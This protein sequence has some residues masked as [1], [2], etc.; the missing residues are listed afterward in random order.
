[1]AK[2]RPQYSGIILALEGRTQDALEIQLRLL[3]SSPH[4]LVLP[5]L[6]EY[7]EVDC[8]D[9]V[10]FAPSNSS[11]SYVS[12]AP[13]SYASSKP[14]TH[15]SAFDARHYVRSVYAAATAR[16]AIVLNFLENDNICGEIHETITPPQKTVFLNGGTATSHAL[17]IEAIREHDAAAG[18]SLE[19]AALIF[20]KLVGNGFAGLRDEPAVPSMQERSRLNVA[21][22]DGDEGVIDEDDS[23]MTKAMRAADALDRKTKSLQPNTHIFDPTITNKP[24]SRSLSLPVYGEDSALLNVDCQQNRASPSN[25]ESRGDITGAVS[26]VHNLLQLEDS[27]NQ[28]ASSTPATNGS[29]IRSVSLGPSSRG[30]TICRRP[31]CARSQFDDTKAALREND[32]GETLCYHQCHQSQPQRAR[33]LERKLLALTNNNA[34]GVNMDH[35]F[36]ASSRETSSVRPQPSSSNRL[37]ARAS[38]KDMS[39]SRNSIDCSTGVSPNGTVI[40][41]PFLSLFE[42]IVIRFDDDVESSTLKCTSAL[43][44]AIQRFQ[45]TETARRNRHDNVTAQN[46]HSKQTVEN[47]QSLLGRRTISSALPETPVSSSHSYSSS[48]SSTASSSRARTTADPIASTSSVDDYDPFAPH[49]YNAGP[50]P[51]LH[52]KSPLAKQQRAPQSIE[53][54]D[55]LT[56][57]RSPSPTQLVDD[58][59]DDSSTRFHVLATAKFSSILALHNALRSFLSTFLS[60]ELT[61]SSSVGET[62]AENTVE[63]PISDIFFSTPGS[64]SNNLWVPLFETAHQTRAKEQSNVRAANFVLA[65]GSQHDV[66]FDLM[67][68]ITGR[69]DALGCQSDLGITRGGRL[70]LRYLIA[71][72]MQTLKAQR[73]WSY[74]KCADLSSLNW[75]ATSMSSSTSL[76]STRASYAL[77][78]LI[79]AQLDLYLRSCPTSSPSPSAARLFLLDYPSEL[80]PV[81][82]ALRQLMGQNMAQVATVIA[83]SDPQYQK[84]DCHQ[85]FQALPQAP[86][87][88]QSKLFSSL[89]YKPP[90]KEP[91]YK[92]ADYLLTSAAGGI[93]IAKFVAAVRKKLLLS[94]MLAPVAIPT[95]ANTVEA[96]FPHGLVPLNLASPQNKKTGRYSVSS[97]VSS[98]AGSMGANGYTRSIDSK[99]QSPTYAKDPMLSPT[100]L[101]PPSVNSISSPRHRASMALENEKRYSSTSSGITRPHPRPLPL[102]IFLNGPTTYSASATLPVASPALS[103]ISMQSMQS[104]ASSLQS[105]Q[106]QSE[107][108]YTVAKATGYMVAATALAPAPVLHPNGRLVAKEIQVSG[109]AAARRAKEQQALEAI[110]AHSSGIS[111]SSAQSDRGNFGNLESPALSCD[112]NYVLDISRLDNDNLKRTIPRNSV[113]NS[114]V[115]TQVH[116][117]GHVSI[118][119]TGDYSDSHNDEEYESG[120]DE[121]DFENDPDMRR[122]MPLFMRDRVALLAAKEAAGVRDVRPAPLRMDLSQQTRLA[123]PR[124]GSVSAARAATASPQQSMASLR[125]KASTNSIHSQYSQHGNGSLT[126]KSGHEG[127]KALRWLG[128]A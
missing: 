45:D 105:F 50:Q 92:D 6:Q 120:P 33:S 86:L 111:I 65:I 126:S 7:L 125:A 108:W 88:S 66:P 1:M 94:V 79:I 53:T 19:R 82:L 24:R 17:C 37:K 84:D 73:A 69:L 76:S 103:C 57:A 44:L 99:L 118:N 51:P 95:A 47:V 98:A 38:G 4:I 114:S 113:R 68:R 75:L 31:F 128:L 97:S 67:S 110:L 11:T 54:P 48:T 83:D 26:N 112:E 25:L 117:Y 13:S 8:Q 93:D 27:T 16:Q 22:E 109:P 127:R 14:K 35:F 85:S 124:P 100:L 106:S 42:D 58:E 40:Y 21:A 23:P 70:D 90:S 18:G 78:T 41:E 56:P 101:S 59:P 71:N 81:V 55:P 9:V 2:S 60:Q 62:D 122:L 64:A 61:R 46:V 10:S 63:N 123:A 119:G 89:T 3:P 96:T 49:E 29:V 102:K 121:D 77:A 15:T 116:E 43:D 36:S 74:E 39:T 72:A 12:C 5:S 107:P 32:M 91:L 115:T 52:F 28:S 87:S 34:L 80:L 30:R 20:D 104:Q